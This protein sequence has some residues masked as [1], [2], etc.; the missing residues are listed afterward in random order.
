MRPFTGSVLCRFDPARVDE[1]R[2]LAVLS[3]VSGV[4]RVLQ[5]GEELPAEMA[6]LLQRALDEGSTL[7]RAA[8]RAAKGLNVDLL[9]F[10]EGRVS[11]G[12]LM[13]FL[14]LGSSA[15]KLA[16]S[17]RLELPELHQ[18]AWWGFRSFATLEEK[19]I[20]HEDAALDLHP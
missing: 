12:T 14:L 17:D 20:E 19:V 3:Q 15:L 18:L 13:A 16:L 6:A 7:S 4:E 2:L 1:A 9:H 10:S 11:L 8:V 5:P